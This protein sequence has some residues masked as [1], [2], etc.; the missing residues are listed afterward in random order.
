LELKE[1][2]KKIQTEEKKIR[3]SQEENLRKFERLLEERR[4]Q[5]SEK[6]EEVERRKKTHYLSSAKP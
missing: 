4:N 6:K 2:K 3:V 5:E 1:S